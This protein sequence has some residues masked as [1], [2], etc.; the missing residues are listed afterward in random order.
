MA[1]LG[2]YKPT[3]SSYDFSKGP[4]EI[5]NAIGDEGLFD[6]VLNIP[7]DDQDDEWGGTERIAFERLVDEVGSLRLIVKDPLNSG[8]QGLQNRVTLIERVVSI[9]ATAE[10]DAITINNTT[11]TEQGITL[12]TTETPFITTSADT[13]NI[14]IG[15]AT[16]SLGASG[17]TLPGV[18]T[19]ISTRKI[20]VFDNDDDL[21][22][23]TSEATWNL[24]TASFSV[25][26]D[27][28]SAGI[29]NG[30]LSN[31]TVDFDGSVYTLG[32]LAVDG[33]ITTISDIEASQI[34]LK[35]DPSSTAY[36]Y[37]SEATRTLYAA[38]LSVG[39]NIVSGTGVLDNLEAN[40]VVDDAGDLVSVGDITIDGYLN[41]S[42]GINIEGDIYA[43]TDFTI[44]NSSGNIT[45]NSG[46]AL[47]LSSELD[48]S[49]SSL[50]DITLS[51]NSLGAVIFKKSGVV[52]EDDLPI[53][54]S[55]LDQGTLC[56]D[57]S[58]FLRMVL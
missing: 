57:A 55:T 40:F 42:S 47:T 31:F 45:I 35:E 17:Y 51:P 18:A 41:T 10:D 12:G 1:N 48:L 20:S 26:A 32:T 22:L 11:I 13:L 50:N 7:Q 53:Y 27:V 9:G 15:S 33:G 5:Y 25:G 14:N 8:T 3:A 46:G 52:F 39:A 4:K 29:I 56:R 28:P 24:H 44:S 49:I 58:G 54:N 16:Y 21:F 34:N 38:K 36:V 2:A 37:T 6:V 19:D 23:T 30:L 43:L